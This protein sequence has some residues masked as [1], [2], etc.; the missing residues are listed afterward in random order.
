MLACVCV[1]RT[2]KKTL[3]KRI[4]GGKLT[5]KRRGSKE[6]QQQ[7]TGKLP[8]GNGRINNPIKSST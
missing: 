2:E 4:E 1:L 6:G 8:N 3:R 7:E 5:K